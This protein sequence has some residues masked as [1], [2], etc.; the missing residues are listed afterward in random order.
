MSHTEGRSP[1]TLRYHNVSSKSLPEVDMISGGQE[2]PIGIVHSIV[3]PDGQELHA[4]NYVPDQ[5]VEVHT[6]EVHFE[7][8]SA[9]KFVEYYKKHFVDPCVNGQFCHGLAAHTMN[10]NHWTNIH[11]GDRVHAPD[12]LESGTAYSIVPPGRHANGADRG[13]K[14]SM[15]GTADPTRN[16]SVLGQDLPMAVMDNADIMHLYGGEIRPSFDRTDRST[17]RRIRFD[18]FKYR[19]GQLIRPQARETFTPPEYVPPPSALDKDL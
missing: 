7:K 4:K 16:V 1:I 9:A 17:Q 6:T 14:H 3:G 12:K 2:Y 15:F 19:L 11:H 10:L 13:S 18:N 5:D 8:E